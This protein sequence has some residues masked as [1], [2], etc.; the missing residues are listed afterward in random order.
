MESLSILCDI[1]KTILSREVILMSINHKTH[2]NDI[3]YCVWITYYEFILLEL[4]FFLM[5]RLNKKDK[6]NI[7]KLI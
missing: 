7:C 5:C 4:I 1:S 3:L 2:H 6:T